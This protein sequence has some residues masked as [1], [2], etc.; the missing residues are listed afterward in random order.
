MERILGPYVIRHEPGGSGIAKDI[1][2]AQSLFEAE[3][4][5][6]NAIFRLNGQKET[7]KVLLIKTGALPS[8]NETLKQENLEP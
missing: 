1:D 8:L 3:R 2:Y 6:G 4:K 5:F 7:G